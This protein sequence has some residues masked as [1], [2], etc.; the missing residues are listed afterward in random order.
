M[1]VLDPIKIFVVAEQFNNTAAFLIH[2]ADSGLD[3]DVSM[4]TVTCRAFALELY[5]KCLIAMDQK[6]NPTRHALSDLFENLHPGRQSE[7]RSHF[8]EYADEV[9]QRIA[10]EHAAGNEE[11]PVVDFDFVLARSSNAFVR[12]RYIFEAGLREGEG[13]MADPIILCARRV[14]LDAHSDWTDY[15]QSTPVLALKTGPTSPAP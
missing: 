1:P 15:R 2:A 13:W 3:F 11:L 5:F 8:D 12:A 7:V 10:A 4:P 6:D 14:I 9:K